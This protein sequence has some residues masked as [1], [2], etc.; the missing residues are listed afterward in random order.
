MMKNSPA[1]L[2]NQPKVYLDA[3][4]DALE[5]FEDVQRG[6]N[7]KAFMRQS[8]HDFLENESKETAL[9]VY[10]NFFDSYRIT[11]AGEENPFVDL[12]D[13]LKSYEEN[14]ATLIDKQ[15]DHYVHAVNAFILG[16]C[17][18]I[19]NRNYR[20]AFDGKNLDKSDYPFS[21][22]TA[23]EEF[24]YRWGIACLFHDVGYPVEIVGK[25]IAKFIDFATGVDSDIEV[26]SHLEFENFSDFNAITEV[27]P[28]RE[29][30][31]S[32]YEKY[33]SSVYV[34]L[35]KPVDLL[36]HK[37]HLSLG[38]DLK[39]IQ[40]A[41]NNFVHTMAKFGFIDHGFY[42]AIIVLRWYG[43]LIQSCGYKPEYFFY[44]IL[45][46]ASAILLHNYY[47][48]VLMKPPFERGPL[49]PKDHTIAYLLILCDE[50]QEWNRQ[51]YGI[52]TKNRI[53]PG[54]MMLSVSDE[55]LDI[56]YI[57]TTG[58]LP[59][60]FSTEKEE[61]L[62]ELLDLAA[63]FPGGFCVD[64]E[65]ENGQEVISR[66]PTEADQVAPRLLLENLED[67]AIA[68][69]ERYNQRQKVVSP[70]QKPEYPNFA[71]LPDSL[72]FS[73]L[74][75]ARSIVDR[76]HFIG[77]KIHPSQQAGNKISKIPKKYVDILARIEH[78]D[79]VKERLA[80]GWVFG[81][82]KDAARKVSPYLVGYDDLP[83]EIKENDRDAIR[84]IPELLEMVG[85]AIFTE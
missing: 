70:D 29:F 69:H 1:N 36:A 8:V 13:V 53:Q 63:I 54:K 14:A 3:F 23:H 31:R 7:Y 46:S 57:S 51:A 72:K 22:D 35:L 61:L 19:Q 25:Q 65:K 79:W 56:T 17:I 49:S 66:D 43:F 41:L 82:E 68:I 71:D 83:E 77:W 73:N 28:K 75:Q 11:L 48:F 33:D 10:E 84:N 47:R 12:L 24:F 16:L 59:K 30:I 6:H 55:R 80:S 4:F 74:R 2:T 9:A 60:N 18:Y 39:T 85:L 52:L 20:A 58:K 27:I 40:A 81:S 44:P 62:N 45:D 5:V 21:Y 38:I 42:S 34:D 15:R 32:Y 37:L 26:R 50:L 76:V 64:C 67:I 78:E